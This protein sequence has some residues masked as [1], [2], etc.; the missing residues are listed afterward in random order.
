MPLGVWKIRTYISTKIQSALWKKLYFHSTSSSSLSLEAVISSQSA[1][2][3]SSLGLFIY[4]PPRLSPGPGVCPRVPQS[5][6]NRRGEHKGTT[7]TLAISPPGH[8]AL[9]LKMWVGIILPAPSKGSHC[10]PKLLL[11]KKHQNVDL[12]PHREL[13]ALIIIYTSWKCWVILF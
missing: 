2:P 8:A 4:H 5:V 10:I 11:S 13:K 3:Q 7:L 1:A 9:R 6:W 12:E